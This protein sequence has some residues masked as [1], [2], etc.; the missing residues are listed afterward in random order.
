MD[1]AQTHMGGEEKL[2]DAGEVSGWSCREGELRLAAALVKEL[3]AGVVV[4][5]DMGEVNAAA[6]EEERK[7]SWKQRMQLLAGA[8]ENVILYDKVQAK[9]R[10]NIWTRVC[11]FRKW[12]QDGYS[13]KRAL[14]PMI[15][16]E[17]ERYSSNRTCTL[18]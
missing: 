8:D 5:H 18:I 16:S 2:S 11:D 14:A 13:S 7:G 12:K 9:R 15:Y 3:V 17:I 10:N 1:P 4:G 6:V